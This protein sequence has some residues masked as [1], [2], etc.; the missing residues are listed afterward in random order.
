MTDERLNTRQ[1]ANRFGLSPITL[2]QWRTHAEGPRFIKEGPRIF[3]CLSDVRVFERQTLEQLMTR[4]LAS[5]QPLAMERTMASAVALPIKK[6]G[7][8][9]RAVQDSAEARNDG[10]DVDAR[11]AS[12]PSHR[13]MPPDADW[14]SDASILTR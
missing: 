11:D 10:G 2:Q 3:Y 7:R 14:T 5:D 4:I 1:L 12:P 8:K 6:G 9:R 13:V